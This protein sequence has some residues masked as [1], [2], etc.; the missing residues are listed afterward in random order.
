MN[1]VFLKFQAHFSIC[2]KHIVWTL[3]EKNHVTLYKTKENI[4]SDSV[5]KANNNNKSKFI[6]RTV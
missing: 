6:F 1:Q 4:L 3:S 5:L 2:D